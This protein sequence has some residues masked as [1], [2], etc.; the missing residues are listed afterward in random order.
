MTFSYN[1]FF[2]I[3][4]QKGKIFGRKKESVQKNTRIRKNLYTL[5]IFPISNEKNNLYLLCIKRFMFIEIFDRMY[6][7]R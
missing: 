2:I 4:S 7:C 6:K 5:Y 1:Y 3:P